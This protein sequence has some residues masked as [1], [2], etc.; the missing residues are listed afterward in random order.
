MKV[1]PAKLRVELNKKKFKAK[2]M[3]RYECPF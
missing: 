1:D 2:I 3:D